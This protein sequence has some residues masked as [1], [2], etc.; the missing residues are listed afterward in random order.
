GQTILFERYPHDQT[1]KFRNYADLW[2]VGLSDGVQ[3]QVTDVQSFTRGLVDARWSRD[4]E[5]IAATLLTDRTSHV[6][7]MDADGSDRHRLTSGKAASE[8]PSWSPNGSRVAFEQRGRIVTARPD[9]SHRRVFG[10]RGKD[11][12]WGSC[13]NP[14]SG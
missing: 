3:E 5:R 8:D 7:V 6:V 11:P 9:G 13:P 14:A 1:T 10:G 2:T 4:G 12:S